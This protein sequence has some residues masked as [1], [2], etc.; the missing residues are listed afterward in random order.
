MKKACG[1]RDPVASSLTFKFFL[2]NFAFHMENEVSAMKH[3][4]YEMSTDNNTNRISPVL[5]QASNVTGSTSACSS[6]LSTLLQRLPVPVVVSSKIAD[7]HKCLVKH[8]K[9]R[10]H[11][12]RPMAYMKFAAFIASFRLRVVFKF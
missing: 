12:R 10:I 11:S 9:C 8:L 4:F 3:E 6:S 7:L 1:N 5:L 2:R